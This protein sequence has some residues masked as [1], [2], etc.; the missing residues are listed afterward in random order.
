MKRDPYF[1]ISR[2]F[3]SWME[4]VICSYFHWEIF[5]FFF[6]FR[7]TTKKKTFFFRWKKES[8]ED[9][10]K[11][12]NISRYTFEY[13][14]FAKNNWMIFLFSL[15]SS[16][17][18]YDEWRIYFLGN[19]ST[20]IEEQWSGVEASVGRLYHL[21]FSPPPSPTLRSRTLAVKGG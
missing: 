4:R 14:V 18:T 16:S 15:L 5:L 10:N 13:F 20:K 7:K 2:F 21:V 3:Q 1:G 6:F 11:G 9:L 19:I 12:W 17:R 8:S